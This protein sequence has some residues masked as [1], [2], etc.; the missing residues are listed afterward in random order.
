MKAVVGEQM[1]WKTIG[2]SDIGKIP[3]MELGGAHLRGF[4]GQGVLL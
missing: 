3:G 2:G 4:R 1:N